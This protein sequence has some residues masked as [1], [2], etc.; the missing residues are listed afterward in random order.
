M[1]LW[2]LHP[3]YLDR[4][5]LIACWREGLLAKKVLEGSTKGYTNHPQLIRFKETP[6]PVMA[7]NGYLGCLVEEAL[8]RGYAF[9]I[10]KLQ[11]LSPAFSIEVSNGQLDYEMQHL[12]KKLKQRDPDWLHQ[13]STEPVQANPRFTVVEGSIAAWEVV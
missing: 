2:S 6:D 10:T 12:R 9:D 3:R 1:R 13:L 8:E 5:G 11:P 7:I 4:Q